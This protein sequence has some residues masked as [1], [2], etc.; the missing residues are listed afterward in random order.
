MGSAERGVV[1]EEEE[2]VVVVSDSLELTSGS[3]SSN[4]NKL[5][6]FF[7]MEEGDVGNKCDEDGLARGGARC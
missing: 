5:D 3:G 4:D 6:V 1:T 7:V 2:V